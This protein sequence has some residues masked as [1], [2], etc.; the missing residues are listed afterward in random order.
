[1]V[2]LE[3]FGIRSPGMNSLGDDE[4]R[5]KDRDKRQD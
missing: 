5:E 1:M 3:G 4:E 2:F